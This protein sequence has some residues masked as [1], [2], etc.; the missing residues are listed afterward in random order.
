MLILGRTDNQIKLRGLRIELGEVETVLQAQEGMKYVAVKIQKINNIEHLCAWFTNDH[1]VE[2]P[3]LKAELG[4]TLTPYMVPTAYMQMEKMPFMPNGKLDMKNLPV[5]EVYR[6][7]GE[8]AKSAAEKAFCEIFSELLNVDNVLATESFFDLGGTSLLVT[9]VVIEAGKKGYSIVFGDVF[10]NPTPR[11]LAGLFEEAPAE[12]VSEHDSEIEDYDYTAINELLKKNTLENFRKGKGHSL[13]N[14]L[15]TGATGYLGIH[16]LYELLEKTD[17]KVYC[18]LRSTADQTAE[19]R[20][21][22]LLFYYFDKD[23]RGLLGDRLFVY[24]GDVTK[25]DSFKPLKG[26]DI[27]TVINCAAIVKH[28]SHDSIIHDVNV[29]GAKNVIDFCLETGA[30]MIQTSTMSVIEIGYKDTT[31]EGFSPSEQTLYCGQDLTNQYVRSKFLA[32][33]AILEAVL[34]RGLKAKIMRYGN[35][36]ARYTDGEF[37]VNFESNAAMGQLRA[38]AILGCAPYDQAEDLMEFSPISSVAD[39]TVR[40]SGTPEDC[41]VFNVITDQYISKVHIFEEMKEVGYPVT[42]MERDEYE[43]AFAAAGSDPRKA[44][45]LTSLMAYDVG[46][47][48]RERVLY[49]MDREH[50]LQVLYRLG[51]FWPTTSWDYIKRFM[52]VLNGLGFFEEDF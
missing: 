29:N 32:E 25:P 49:D 37:Q 47:G 43:K 21:T 28:F 10:A 31:P 39:A 19:K 18:L 4:K 16:I 41:I 48:E 8:E 9:Q 2:I 40:L 23:Y 20:L 51:F 15:M 46:K 35:L 7:E 50:T 13:G 26:E 45:H 44:A 33:R 27:D 52:Q 34:T 30:V 36:S 24:E 6:G 3:A 12:E 17:C 14:V 5:P 1:K 38:Y 22:S 42:L 11:A